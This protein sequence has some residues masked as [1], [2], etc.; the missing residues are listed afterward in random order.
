MFVAALQFGAAMHVSTPRTQRSI[1]APLDHNRIDR[2]RAYAADL[3]LV[4]GHAVPQRVVFWTL[5][6]VGVVEGRR[7]EI[8]S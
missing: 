1:I 5:R 6:P 7:Y 8:P 4:L 2:L 3:A